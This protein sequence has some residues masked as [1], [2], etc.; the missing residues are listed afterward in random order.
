MKFRPVRMRLVYLLSRKEQ[1][2]RML[3]F[4][5]MRSAFCRGVPPVTS[6]RDYQSILALA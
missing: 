6:A 2:D 4:V 1:A 3:N 5:L